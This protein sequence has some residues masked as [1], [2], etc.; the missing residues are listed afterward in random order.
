MKYF[1]LLLPFL[2]LNSCGPMQAPEAPMSQLQIREMQTHDIDTDDVK[3]V[4]K[5]M[6]HV[7]QDEG[8]TIQ[9][10]NVDLGLL[11]A[12][13]DSDIENHNNRV[14]L[15]MMMGNDARWDKRETVEASANVS[16]FGKQTRVRVSF[17]RR[18]FDNIGNVS[19]V[20]QVLEAARYQSFFSKLSKSL[21]IEKEGI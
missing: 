2:F 5:A 11:T 3:M 18:V 10:A 16:S 13:K 19:R 7:L 17:Q 4:M 20:E 1:L 21:F 12:A 9:N 14:M 8:F 6:V 15:Q